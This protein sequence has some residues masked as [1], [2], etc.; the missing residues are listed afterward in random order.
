MA[1]G[2]DNTR[3]VTHLR[4]LV[5]EDELLIR[6]SIAE[7]LTHAGCLV[8]E[9]PDGATALRVLSEADGSID[10][11]VL[12]YRLPDSN[13]L[14]L[15]RRIRQ[16]SPR[17]AVLMMTAFG[18]PEVITQALGLG[19]S[20]VIQKPFEMDDLEALIVEASGSRPH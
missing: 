6:W 3:G 18:T 8:T 7:T 1:G 14:T 16:L 19:V 11:V 13:D 20:R 5:V 17:S 15:L 4:V 12:D 10:V 9:A 2:C